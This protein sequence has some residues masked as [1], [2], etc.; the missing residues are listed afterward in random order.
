MEC[1]EITKII[2]NKCDKHSDIYSF[3]DTLIQTVFHIQ[4]QPSNKKYFEPKGLLS[5][6][7][8]TMTK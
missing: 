5:E 4:I 8:K 1:Q 2:Q 7:M 6:E 3:H